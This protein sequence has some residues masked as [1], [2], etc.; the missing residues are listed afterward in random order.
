MVGPTGVRPCFRRREHRPDWSTRHH[1]MPSAGFVPA[2][3][4]DRRRQTAPLRHHLV[5]PCKKAVRGKVVS[6]VS[7]VPDLGVPGVVTRSGLVARDWRARENSPPW[8]NSALVRYVLYLPACLPAHPPIHGNSDRGSVGPP[9]VGYET[10]IGPVCGPNSSSFSSS[11]APP[12]AA[13]PNTQRFGAYPYCAATLCGGGGG[14]KVMLKTGGRFV[15]RFYVFNET[16]V[17]ARRSLASLTGLWIGRQTFFRPA[18][19]R[20]HPSR[21]VARFRHSLAELSSS[22][23]SPRFSSH[24]PF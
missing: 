12:F 11:P 23:G 10:A 15:T 5:G 17:V 9:Y 21:P 4:T 19:P 18:T 20:F 1:A 2:S 24:L 6:A 8:G 13:R 3:D 7:P 16:T 14:P 22:A